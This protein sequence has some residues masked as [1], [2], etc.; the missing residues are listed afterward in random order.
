MLDK[1]LVSD[2]EKL[3]RM[4]AKYFY[5]RPQSSWVNIP[6]NTNFCTH[7]MFRESDMVSKMWL[8]FYDQNRLSGD[9]TKSLAYFEKPSD[10]ESIEVT[11]AVSLIM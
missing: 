4:P 3:E 11:I 1:V 7:T 8:V 9:V 6:A 5:Y 10:L 2:K